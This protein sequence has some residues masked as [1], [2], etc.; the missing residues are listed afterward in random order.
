MFNY[1]IYILNYNMFIKILMN[2]ILILIYDQI[3]E[4][5]RILMMIFNELIFAK[6]GI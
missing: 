1:V 6:D 3:Y 4:D 2:L 5:M